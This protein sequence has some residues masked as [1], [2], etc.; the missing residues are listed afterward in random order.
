MDVV[1]FSVLLF[2]SKHFVDCSE[3]MAHVNVHGV[4]YGLYLNWWKY[5]WGIEMVTDVGLFILD[6]LL[7]DVC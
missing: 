4:P 7:K 1:I 3:M 5:F 6:L 2:M